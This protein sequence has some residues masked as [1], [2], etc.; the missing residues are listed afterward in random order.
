MDAVRCGRGIPTGFTD[1]QG[2]PGLWVKLDDVWR[3]SATMREAF[4][5][6]HGSEWRH[7]HL[8]TLSWAQ[9]GQALEQVAHR[10]GELWFGVRALDISSDHRVHR[11]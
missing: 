7:P 6:L 5:A 10:G 1:R 3:S 4:D 9:L 11:S 8:D 2:E